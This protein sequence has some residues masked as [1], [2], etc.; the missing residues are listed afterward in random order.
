MKTIQ[1]WDHSITQWVQM[2]G[3]RGRLLGK[4]TRE[5]NKA[6]QIIIHIEHVENVYPI[7]PVSWLTHNQIQS[8]KPYN[9]PRPFQLSQRSIKN[10]QNKFR[11]H[12]YKNKA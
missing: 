1:I 4:N 9:Y 12:T 10:Q 7:Y 11:L 3:L 5:K 8:I 6:G 2:K